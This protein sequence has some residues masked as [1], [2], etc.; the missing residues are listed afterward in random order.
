MSSKAIKAAT[1]HFLQFRIQYAS[2]ALLYWDYMLTFRDEVKVMWSK[3]SMSKVS[4]LLYGLCRYALL[5][6]VLYLLAVAGKLGDNCNTWYKF[7]GAISVLG[8][9]A[10]LTVFTM[11][12]YAV[13]SQNKFILIGLGAIAVTCVILDCLHVP[14]LKCTGSSS[15]Q[16][17]NTL[18]SILVCVFEFLSTGLTLFR[19]IQSLRAGGPHKSQ[20]GTFH[21]VIAEQ[22]ILY[23][24]YAHH[25]VPITE[26]PADSS[27]LS[28]VFVFTTTA[29][30]LNFRA[31]N[32][33]FQRLLNG[34]TLPLS[35]LM[36][37][38]FLLH[39]RIWNKRSTFY[40]RSG[41]HAS[42]GSPD[43]DHP[44]PQL[45]AFQVAGNAV[46]SEFGED[47]VM[48]ARSARSTDSD[49][50][51][52]RDH[53]IEKRLGLRQNDMAAG[54]G[55]SSKGESFG[56][57]VVEHGIGDGSQTIDEERRE[58]GPRS[59]YGKRQLVGA[60]AEMGTPISV[61]ENIDFRPPVSGP[62]ETSA[63]TLPVVGCSKWASSDA[64]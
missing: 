49:L 27:T 32:G 3:D 14:G 40:S 46:V 17:A 1:T 21:Y 62:S 36:T 26:Q 60:D 44:T 34:L 10:V 20:K 9:A 61:E 18:L 38:R 19:C 45:S 59:G 54:I 11:R 22:G 23:F 55:M 56:D 52:H 2:I 25:P 47:P 15:I 29:A 39:I 16:I 48:V 57:G 42:M 6:N 12:T 8:R 43:D 50:D 28:I 53:D 37:A 41:N 33:F 31:P 64:A 30:I 4:T 24:G 7:V 35:G 51:G 63:D 13:W 58:Q 5:A